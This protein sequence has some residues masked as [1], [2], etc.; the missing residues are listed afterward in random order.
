MG[1]RLDLSRERL[2]VL[3]AHSDGAARMTAMVRV[4]YRRSPPCLASTLRIWAALSL[5]IGM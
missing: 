3:G 4:L 2:G 5:G 1:R